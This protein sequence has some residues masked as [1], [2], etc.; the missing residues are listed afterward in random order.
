MARNPLR[1]GPRKG[2]ANGVNHFCRRALGAISWCRGQWGLDL[3][4]RRLLRCEACSADGVS[5]LGK[6]GVVRALAAREYKAV[7]TDDGWSQPLPDGRERWREDAI[8]DVLATEGSEVLFVAGC[9]DNQVRS[10]RSSTK[11]SR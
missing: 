9:E 10:T 7:D 1:R 8:A 5:G 6:S 3:S 4:D 11:L 2:W